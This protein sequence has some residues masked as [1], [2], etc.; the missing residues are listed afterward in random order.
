MPGA[1]A[2]DMAKATRFNNSK[3]LKRSDIL[4]NVFVSLK[5]H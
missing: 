5:L 2:P 4:E 3:V 1:P